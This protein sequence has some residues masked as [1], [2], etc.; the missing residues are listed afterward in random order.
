MAKY[1][2]LIYGDE[3][4]YA[5]GGEAAFDEAIRAHDAFSE[6]HRAAI[7][8]GEALRETSTATTIRTQ[9]GGEPLVTDG[10]FVE[11]K[12]ALGGYYVVEAPDLDA[13]VAIAK[14]V[15]APDGGVEVRPIWEFE[16]A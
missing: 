5:A 1:L 10:P 16:E 2:I 7:V 8:G 11:T 13:A 6:K 15:P 3:Q 12:E 9:P 4:A 14:D